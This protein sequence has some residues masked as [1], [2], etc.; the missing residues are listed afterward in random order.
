MKTPICERSNSSP[1]DRNIEGTGDYAL[2]SDSKVE[3][4]K[5]I[6]LKHGIFEPNSS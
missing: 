6:T 5:M 4:D 2:Q 3:V 1:A